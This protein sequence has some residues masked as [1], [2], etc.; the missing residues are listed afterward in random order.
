MRLQQFQGILA[1]DPV[2]DDPEKP[3]R[4]ERHG[5]RS[6]EDGEALGDFD[7]GQEIEPDGHFFNGSE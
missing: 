1:E 7:L 2:D 3:M 4:T 6:G 5:D